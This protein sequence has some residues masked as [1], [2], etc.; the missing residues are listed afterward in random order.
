MSDTIINWSIYSLS[1]VMLVKQ[2]YTFL[3]C[4][5]KGILKRSKSE[6]FLQF[7]ENGLPLVF[8]HAK[9]FT[10][11]Y[12]I[13]PYLVQCTNRNHLSSFG[14]YSS[15]NWK[16]NSW[17]L[18]LYHFAQPQ[19]VSIILNFKCV[20]FDGVISL[21]MKLILMLRVGFI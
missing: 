9:W 14:Q 3:S 4:S 8:A 16:Q 7:W 1:A 11:Q 2:L 18:Q 21:T 15:Y 19:F 12:K 10:I 20:Y 5:T 6:I 17:L 13:K